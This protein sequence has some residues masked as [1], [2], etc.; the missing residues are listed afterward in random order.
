MLEQQLSYS[1]IQ[2]QLLQRGAS[3]LNSTPFPIEPKTFGR[4]CDI[5]CISFKY[6]ILKTIEKQY[7]KA[8]MIMRICRICDY[9]EVEV[10]PPVENRTVI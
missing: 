5:E 1:E 9:S 3:Y 2:L 7:G 4:K 8:M 10:F 6:H